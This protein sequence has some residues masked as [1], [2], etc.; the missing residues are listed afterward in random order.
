MHIYLTI[1][2]RY[3]VK[4]DVPTEKPNEVLLKEICHGFLSLNGK[5]FDW[6]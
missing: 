2:E 5:S 1:S 6:K 3:D 4:Y